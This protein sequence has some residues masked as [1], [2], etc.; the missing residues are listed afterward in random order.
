MFGL[1]GVCVVKIQRGLPLWFTSQPHPQGTEGAG[2]E[3]KGQF[4]GL[5][6]SSQG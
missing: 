4:Q 3:S 5:N 2:G 1:Y 6:G